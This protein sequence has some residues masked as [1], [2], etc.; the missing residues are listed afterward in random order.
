MVSF[1]N[2]FFTQSGPVVG[3]EVGGQGEIRYVLSWR[4]RLDNICCSG[5]WLR[6]L[7]GRSRRLCFLSGNGWASRS[8]C[9]R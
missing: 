7:K 2:I 1:L 5:G 4:T 8:G 6:L 3:E 9:G